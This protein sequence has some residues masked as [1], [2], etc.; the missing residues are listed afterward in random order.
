MAKADKTPASTTTKAAAPKPAKAAAPK[1]FDA[2]ANALET[3]A[4]RE[5]RQAGEKVTET[6]HTV[7]AGQSVRKGGKRFL[8][9]D[10]VMLSPADA[11]RMIAGRVVAAG[12][13]NTK[14]ADAAKAQ[15]D[16]EAEA[17]EAAEK[18]KRE[19]DEASAKAAAAAAEAAGQLSGAENR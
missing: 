18:A 17:Q 7:L 14:D 1:P 4:E 11:E 2:K 8:A 9:G 5:A 19:A 13:G 10:T 6:A 16:A 3:R 12:A 15:A